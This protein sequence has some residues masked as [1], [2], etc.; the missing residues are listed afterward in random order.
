MKALAMVLAPTF[1]IVD[2]YWVLGAVYAN[3]AVINRKQSQSTKKHEK[4]LTTPHV[5]R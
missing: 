1:L 2:R 3:V 5:R 4:T